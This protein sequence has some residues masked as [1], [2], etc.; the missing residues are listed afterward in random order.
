M[1]RSSLQYRKQ[2]QSLLPKGR[3]WNRNE[4]SILTKVLWGMAEE[5]SRIDGRASN[6]INEKILATTNELITEH[7]EDYGLPE[8]GQELQQTIELRRN[9]LKSKLLEV[10]QQDKGYLE[11][12]CNAFG[13]NNVWIEEFRP[14]WCGIACAGDPCGGQLNLFF[15]KINI[16]VD[17][18]KDLVIAGYDIGFDNGFLNNAMFYTANE[19]ILVNLTKIIAKMN[20]LKP[21]HTHVLFDW[22]NAGFD[23]GFGRGFRRF[24]HYD[25][26]WVG[27]GFDVSF[28][29]GFE[30]NSSYH[31]VN[32]TGGFN[33][34]FSI[35][36]DR[37]SGGG[38]SPDGFQKSEI[39]IIGGF[40]FGFS[41]GFDRESGAGFSC[42][43]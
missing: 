29:D 17:G 36:F 1:A 41:L 8:E 7:E 34:G 13:Y 6:L 18:I 19:T 27:L 31:G 33:Y 24:Y 15:W 11:D 23:R 20:K 26:Y 3:L 25:N 30:N 38:F 42:P 14:A 12:I 2:L 35:D 5:L 21:G 40:S 22:W 16:D 28:S 10:G 4:D 37:N 43:A 39:K 9:E 32:Y